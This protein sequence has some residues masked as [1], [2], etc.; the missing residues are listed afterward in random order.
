VPEIKMID[1]RRDAGQGEGSAQAGK[2]NLPD[3][4][5]YQGVMVDGE[6][7]EG[8]LV[9]PDGTVYEGKFAHAQL[10]EGKLIR[11]DGCVCEG[12]FM[13][14]ELIK[15]KM[16][17]PDGREYFHQ[18]FNFGK[19]RM[20]GKEKY[21][22][23]SSRTT[24]LIK[25]LISSGYSA[26]KAVLPIIGRIFVT[27]NWLDRK[28]L[29]LTK[30]PFIDLFPKEILTDNYQE[31]SIVL[32]WSSHGFAEDLARKTAR[33]YKNVGGSYTYAFKWIDPGTDTTFV[34]MSVF[35]DWVPEADESIAK[36]LHDKMRQYLRTVIE[37][38]A[39]VFY[40]LSTLKKLEREI[41]AIKA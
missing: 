10:V 3:G 4:R 9:I 40:D 35:T 5:V 37:T 12:E 1:S 20:T 41:P 38:K 25:Y 2:L 18:V 23:I 16:I 21:S 8:K 26:Q 39:I 7:T 33:I 30:G 14:G 13:N 31:A 28:K 36:L 24:P 15:G 6:L 11:P 17:H 34:E 19:N 29:P 32:Y 27:A 22:A